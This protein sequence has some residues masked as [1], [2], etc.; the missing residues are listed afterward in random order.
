MKKVIFIGG[1]SYSGSTF[2]GMT[3]ANQDNGLAVG[4]IMH[5]FRPTMPHHVNRLCGCGDPGCDF[6]ERIRAYQERDLY[7]GIFDLFSQVDYVVDTSKDPVWIADQTQTLRR[8][9]F[10]PINLLIWKDPI[11]FVMSCK[12]RGRLA[13]WEEMWVTYHRLYFTLFPDWRSVRYRQYV[14]DPSLLESICNY[15]QI[16][17]TAGQENYW[18][19]THHIY[20]GNHS[21]KVHLYPVGSKGFELESEKIPK[22][23]QTSVEKLHRKIYKQEEEVDESLREMVKKCSIAK[24]IENVLLER[25]VQA[26]GPGS[27]RLTKS[28]KLSR[29]NV[30][31]HRTK[32][33]IRYR[34]GKIKFV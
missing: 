2:L 4:E 27:W 24:N 11:D 25:D 34:Q 17:Y 33:R 12:K 13:Q 9:G 5:V 6:W 21:A 32:R 30:L 28:L 20:G 7:Q 26:P 29:L 10:Q 15:L 8:Y 31:A 3:L 14:N 1:T 19:R 16:P 23:S 18:E 22:S